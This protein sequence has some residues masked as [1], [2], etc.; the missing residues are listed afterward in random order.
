MIEH[1]IKWTAPSQLWFETANS[2][3]DLVRSSMTR[4]AILRFASDSFMEDLIKMLEADPAQVG[5]LV[6]N[7]ETWRG[8]SPAPAANSLLEPV[9]A[10]SKFARKLERFRLS[11]ERSRNGLS[12]GVFSSVSS[13]FA[14]NLPPLKLYQPAHQRYYLVAAHLVC[15]ITGLPD[16]TI[17]PGKQERATFVIRR[18]LPAEIPHPRDPMPRPDSQW[19]E[20]AM[21]VTPTGNG[22][23]KVART[24]NQ[25]AAVLVPGEE[26]LPL[27]N[28]S[29]TED[30]GRR[31]KLIA[32]V[33]PVGKR[34]TYMGASQRSAGTEPPS[35]GADPRMML[36]WSDVTEPWKRVI[37]TADAARKLQAAP[38]A[39]PVS[40]DEAMDAAAI[41]G[42][43]KTTREQIQTTSWYILLDLLKLLKDHIPNLW[44]TITGQPVTVPLNDAQDDLLA[45]LGN[46]TIDATYRNKL[47]TGTTDPNLRVET[48]L[49][50]ALL[51]MAGGTPFDE[52]DAADIETKLESVITPYNREANNA[53]TV[54]LPFLFPLADTDP[55]NVG[56]LPPAKPGAPVDPDALIAALDRIDYLAELIENALPEL[57]S[58]PIAALPIASQKVMDT[59]EGWFVIRCAFERPACGPLEPPIVSDPTQPFQMAG[60]FDPDAPARPIRIALPIDT[61]PAGLRKFDKNTAFMISDILCGQIDRMKG[62]TL[63]DLIRSV[64]PWP[65]HKDLSVPEKA[66]C[67]SKDDASLQAGMICSLSIPIITICALILLMII[68]NLL[69]IIFKWIPYFLIC[70]P[71]PG[72]KGKK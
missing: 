33:V 68:V 8:P 16:H 22:W 36:F 26:T 38:P 39:F 34:E 15:G 60:F 67:K 62:L 28:M 9:G 6:A 25:A 48:S 54:W 52:D 69:N 17:D 53:S 61:T 7:P 45:A 23:Q 72:F 47:L 35:S 3:N 5:S 44:Q 37:E 63:G 58:K 46:T 32:G 4:P 12:S 55:L 19:E 56:P 70:F 21:V 57:P 43:T 42:F 20:Y 1:E 41:P 66:P 27:F 65:L 18:I 11:T 31:R 30:D 29:F 2:T 10:K 24:T 71:L 51:A 14:P 13:L 40:E 64:L 50:N 59:R 49:R